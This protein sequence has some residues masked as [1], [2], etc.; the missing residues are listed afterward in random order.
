MEEIDAKGNVVLQ[1][2]GASHSKFGYASGVSRC[3]GH[4]PDISQ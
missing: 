3:T 2:N 4:P 1:M